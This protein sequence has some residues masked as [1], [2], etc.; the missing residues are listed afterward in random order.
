MS[1][2]K[3]QGF[4]GKAPK[5]FARMLPVEM[6]QEATNTRLDTGRLEGWKANASVSITPVASYSITTNTK[7]LFKYGSNFWIGSNE[8]VDFIRSPI[9]EDPHNRIY[10]TGSGSYPKLTTESI[11]GSGTYYR[12]GV[13]TPPQF[14]SAPALNPST[15][16]NVTTEEPVSVSYIYTYVS[17]FGEEG[18]PITADITHILDKRSDQ[19]VNITF[20]TVVAPNMSVAKKRL[21]RTDSSGT[22]RRVA[23]VTASTYA[24]SISDA[25]LG[26]AIPTTTHVGPPD[27]NATD[28]PDGQMLGL[29]SLPNGISAGF[30]GQTVCFSEAF[31]PHA[32]PKDNRL[33]V[34]SPIVGLAP[35]TNG[36]LVLTK[37]KPA[38]ISGL[39]PRSMSMSEIDSTLSC[40]SKNSIVDMGAYAI[41]ASPDGLV[42]ATE[43]GLDLITEP[44]LTR[45]Q[46]QALVPSSIKAFYYEGQYLAFYNDGSESKGFIFDPRGGKNA[47]VKLD[48]HATAGFNDLE[49]DELYLVVGGSVVKFA[50]SGTS[51]TYVWKSKKFHSEKPVNMGVAKVDRE[52]SGSVTMKFYADGVLKHTQAVADSNI[53]R[54]PSGYKAKEFEFEL[55]SNIPVNS[56]CIYEAAGEVVS[57]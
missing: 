26:E 8:D 57:G 34:K 7:T 4:G 43:Q 13:P 2:V 5:V 40:V 45:D 32:Y 56:V 25:A 17:I 31:L 23:E 55:T 50:T 37:E 27:D 14:T 12:L 53:F 48:F 3:V 39:D 16:A 46:W 42:R 22:Y 20:P 41:Y 29:I 52:G 47:Y 35:M 33:T 30:S 15:S 19:S 44:I 38:M 51:S 36:V 28:H 11:V 54:L 49:T 24:D 10:L 9:A 6:A 1:G 18:P 21:Y